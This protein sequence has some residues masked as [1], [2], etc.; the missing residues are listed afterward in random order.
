MPKE[1]KYGGFRYH[2]QRAGGL[3][4]Q[5]TVTLVCYGI[6]LAAAAASPVVAARF[7]M[8]ALTPA[9]VLA[10][11]LSTALAVYGVNCMVV[12]GCDLLSWVY[13]GLLVVWTM[14]IVAGTLRMRTAGG[15]VASGGLAPPASIASPDLTAGDMTPYHHPGAPL[16]ATATDIAEGTNRIVQTQ[17]D[18]LYEG[19]SEESEPEPYVS[20]AHA[21]LA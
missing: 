8:Q 15:A 7:D 17:K 6:M 12:G 21:E 1:A 14:G 19:Y 4:A 18:N 13:V 5:A 20:G 9:V 11:V 3:S 2:S 10:V 16:P